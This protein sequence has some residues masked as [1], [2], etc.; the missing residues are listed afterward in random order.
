MG[1]E[2]LVVFGIVFLL[3][4]SIAS[5][6]ILDYYGIVKGYAD[7]I[8]P[9]FYAYPESIEDYRLYKLG[10]NNPPSTSGEI[11]ITD[12]EFVGFTTKALEITDF[13]QAN[14]NFYI[15]AKLD[16]LSSRDLSLELWVRDDNTGDLKQLICGD[17]VTVDSTDYRTYETSCSSE[18]L[19]LSESDSFYWK[20][21]G[22]TTASI[23]YM[24]MVD[25]NMRI[26]VS[27]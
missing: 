20:I 10:I 2:S 15:K 25:G 5:A 27:V 26:E 23:N 13:Y 7:V 14:Y 11:S 21:Y 16:S 3:M 8:P 19:T 6:G 1:K 17:K 22:L 12:G 24:I 4:I 9:T 18:S